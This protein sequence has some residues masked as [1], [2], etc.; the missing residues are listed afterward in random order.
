MSGKK[1]RVGIV[2]DTRSIRAMIRALLA[3]SDQ[4][5]VVGEAGDPYEAREMIRALNPD[6]ITLDVVM[7]RMDG[8]SFLEKLMRLRPMP[9][10]MV[11]TRTTEK[12]HDAVR[13]LSLGAVDCVDLGSL[14][15][16][17]L[18]IDLASTVLMAAESN[19]GHFAKA[20]RIEA[21]VVSDFR[22]NGRTVLIG[23]S[24]GGVDALM[25][26]LSAYPADGPPTVIAQHMPAAFLAS[27]VDRI[28]RNVAPRASLAEAG[29]AIEPGHIYL[30]AGGAEHVALS[31]QYPPRITL[32]P[33]NGE[34]Y[35][36]SVEV[37]MRSGA[38]HASKVVGVMLTGMGRDGAKGLLKMRQAGA[39][40]I[41]QSGPSCVVD[42]MPK[43]ARNI[44]AACEV[45][46]LDR[47]GASILKSTSVVR[48]AVV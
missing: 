46:P 6:V 3:H 41:V 7:P 10:V 27:F 34:P 40:T 26:V 24:T 9:V 35:V 25:T 23:S 37:L 18:P 12:S 11:S 47:I 15:D 21:D 14:R 22:W 43:A 29:Q 44:G 32:V 17:S 48:K 2:D 19:T 20:N 39:H 36:P 28:D 38:Q 42:G 4:I 5:E 16:G 8:L 45:V 31:R 13:A 33:E 1:V 30:A